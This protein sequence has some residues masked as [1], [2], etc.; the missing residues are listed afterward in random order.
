MISNEL[1]IS[2]IQTSLFWEDKKSNLDSFEKKIQRI[3]SSQPDI[4]VLPEMF[5][6]G[7]TMNSASLAETNSG[8]T[9][10]R[11]VSWSKKYDIAIFGSF[12][13][14]E[15]GNFYNRGFAALPNSQ[16]FFY[17]KRHLFSMS[18]ENN[19][20]SPGKTNTIV[21]Y[22]GWNIALSICYDL[23]FPIWLRNKQNKYDILLVM[24]NWPESRKDAFNILLK[25]RAIENACYVCG[26]NRIGKDKDGLNYSGNSQIINYKGNIIAEG[27]E[28]RDEIITTT[29]RKEELSLFR[30]KFPVWKDAD[31]FSIID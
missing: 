24:A 5:S 30:E 15:N 12:I 19:I 28:N 2:L 10:Q 7:F 1:N 11:V 22:K 29:L 25:A 31:S 6:T 27:N 9:M 8:E 13:A 23:R 26:C 21:S 16:T 3:T 18:G 17:D 20:F 4:V 14:S